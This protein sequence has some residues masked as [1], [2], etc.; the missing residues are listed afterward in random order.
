MTIFLYLKKS[1][2]SRTRLGDMLNAKRIA[3]RCITREKRRKNKAR[4]TFQVHVI[5][6]TER[7][8]HIMCEKNPEYSIIE[9]DSLKT[10]QQILKVPIMR[11]YLFN[12]ANENSY[13]GIVRPRSP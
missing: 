7:K 9:C 5:I 8:E 6:E 3:K 11:C 10:F 4:E 12:V 13:L 2:A 1:G